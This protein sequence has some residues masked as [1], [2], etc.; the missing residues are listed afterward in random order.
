MRLCW[1]SRCLMTHE[2]GVPVQFTESIRREHIKRAF[3][4]YF[5]RLAYFCYPT[6]D[7]IGAH[8][9]ED[10]TLQGFDSPR[11]S[12]QIYVACAQVLSKPNVHRAVEL[13]QQSI[14]MWPHVV[15]CGELSLE[16]M[17]QSLKYA[18]ISTYLFWI[19]CAL[20]TGKQDCATFSLHSQ[21]VHA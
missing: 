2:N 5:S 3:T 15:C 12:L 6:P 9:S 10:G 17:H 16:R 20:T 8:I 19:P 18:R 13:Y 7:L 11:S 1:Q 14:Y 21:P 4:N